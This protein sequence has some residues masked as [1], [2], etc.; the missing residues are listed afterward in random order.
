MFSGQLTLNTVMSA[1]CLLWFLL[2]FSSP[3]PGWST[4]SL[5]RK[6]TN[7]MERMTRI[8]A[9]KDTMISMLRTEAETR[10]SRLSALESELEGSNAMI[11][12]LRKDLEKKDRIAELEEEMRRLASRLGESEE[13][14]LE[15]REML[16]QV[17]NRVVH[18]SSDIQKDAYSIIGAAMP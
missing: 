7:M 5:E 4:N 2:L 6:M 14:E 17:R 11:S 8:E 16:E 13:A 9:T 15:L 3:H 12:A 1:R 18:S 10:E